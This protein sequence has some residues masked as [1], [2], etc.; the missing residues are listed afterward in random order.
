MNLSVTIAACPVC[1]GARAMPRFMLN[2]KVLKPVGYAERSC[3]LVQYELPL[4]KHCFIL[5]H[6]A[7]AGQPAAA[8]LMAFFLAEAERLARES[9]GDAQAFMLIHSGRS[10]RKRP[11]WHLHVF[12]VQH[13]WQ[14]A[15]VY[16]VLG[17]KNAA[18][19]VY[20]A[21][22]KVLG[23]PVPEAASRQDA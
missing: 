6:E 14:K 22:R 15:W 11:N 16:G 10:I 21:A 19:V 1:S 2:H 12:V 9:V 23:R 3:L 17:A 7:A 20:Y 13:R 18:L 8:D 4:L 5:C